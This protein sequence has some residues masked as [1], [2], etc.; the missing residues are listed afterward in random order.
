MEK[1]KY[2]SQE[3]AWPE[4]E[5]IEKMAL[6]PQP[7]YLSMRFLLD[8]PDKPS[9]LGPIQSSCLLNNR[10]QVMSAGRWEK[11]KN[12]LCSRWMQCKIDR[13]K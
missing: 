12:V 3:T 10:Q 6:D 2:R 5:L 7:Y 8:Y 9:I 11:L 4:K 13:K 1:I